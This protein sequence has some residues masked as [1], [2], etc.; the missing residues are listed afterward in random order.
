M[1]PHPKPDSPIERIVLTLV[2]V[3]VCCAPA[4]ILFAQDTTPNQLVRSNKL[5]YVS[6]A[7]VH[8]S[9]REEY[10]PVVDSIA[11]GGR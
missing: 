5:I 3:L 6:Q 11:M 4:S 8:M 1:M 7:Y 9:G 10:V 2:A